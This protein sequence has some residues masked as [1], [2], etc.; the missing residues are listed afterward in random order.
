MTEP[1]L[2]PHDEAEELLP[3]Y[4]TGRL[5]PADRERVE[6]HLTDCAAC[7]GQLRLERRLADEYRAFSPQVEAS[8]LSLRQRIDPSPVSPPAAANSNWFSPL[9]RQL[10]GGLIAAQLAIV[11]VTAGVVSYVG[12]PDAAY[13]ALASAPVVASANAIVIF[14]PQT[15]EEDLRRLL[16]DNRAELVGGPTDANAYVLH[17]PGP[18]RGAAL[19]RLRGSAQVAMAEPIDG[20]TP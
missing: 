13:R 15:R 5:D 1:S 10:V 9:S 16:T 3:W 19:A 4:V 6:K 11:A 18:E 7:Q 8:W 2:D 17:I 14:Q 12:Q 20:Q